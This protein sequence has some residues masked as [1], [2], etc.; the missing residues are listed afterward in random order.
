LIECQLE[1]GRT[2]QIRIHLSEAGHMLCGEKLYHRRLGQPS[3]P[4]ESGAPRLFLHARSLGF[5]HPVTG[6]ELDFDMP[7][8]DDLQEFLDR[9]QG[10]RRPKP[11]DRDK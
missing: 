6:E 4:D 11:R 10:I 8:P 5:A 7:L 3:Q 2:H 9:L 1:T